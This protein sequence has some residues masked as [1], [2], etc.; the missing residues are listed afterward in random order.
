MRFGD[1]GAGTVT[2]GTI[3][4]KLRSMERAVRSDGR[5]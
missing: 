2:E 5:D 3:L 1:S 4:K